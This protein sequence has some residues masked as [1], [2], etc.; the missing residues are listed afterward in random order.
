MALWGKEDKQADAPKFCTN[1]STG[2]SGQEEYGTNVFGID[3]TEVQVTEGISNAGWVRTTTGTGGR[4]GRVTH[5]VLVASR[6][7]IEPAGGGRDTDEG[8]GEG[9]QTP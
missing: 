2:E 6:T 5:E 4:A 7:L 9:E 3:V 8:E 1:A